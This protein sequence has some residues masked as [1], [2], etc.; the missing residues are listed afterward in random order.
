M[1]FFLEE[2]LFLFLRL[3][4]D[5]EDFQL[6]FILLGPLL[7]VLRLRLLILLRFIDLHLF[8]NLDATLFNA[9]LLDLFVFLRLTHDLVDF[10]I[11]FIFLGPL[12]VV[13]RLRLL[14]LLRFIDLHLF[15]I[16]DAPLLDLFVFLTL[17]ILIAEF[18][19][20]ILN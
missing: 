14:I 11:I 18:I 17:F 20:T 8:T 7:V 3:T 6:I 5:L 16:L 10:L 13:L 9:P 19:F 2:D 4:H 12:L 1:V 15:T